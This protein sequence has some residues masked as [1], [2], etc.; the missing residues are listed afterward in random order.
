MDRENYLLHG[1]F[2]CQM[3]EARQS[4]P[5]CPQDRLP[6]PNYVVLSEVLAYRAQRLGSAEPF[7]SWNRGR[8]RTRA[9]LAPLLPK[10]AG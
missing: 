4:M 7:L 6:N 5:E 10:P 1:Q 3:I 2:V 8:S 9:A